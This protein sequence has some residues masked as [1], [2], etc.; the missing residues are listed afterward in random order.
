LEGLETLPLR[1]AKPGSTKCSRFSLPCFRRYCLVKSCYL[2]FIVS[3]HFLNSVWLDALEDPVAQR[4]Q[5]ALNASFLCIFGLFELGANP[6]LASPSP[7]SLPHLA[8]SLS[9]LFF[10]FCFSSGRH[11]RVKQNGAKEVDEH[12]FAERYR[13]ASGRITRPFWSCYMTPGIN[14]SAIILL[15]HFLGILPTLSSWSFHL[16]YWR[17]LH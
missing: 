5:I 8:D 15:C 13:L 12:V 7:R 11:A 14:A 17:F 10:L 1:S 2:A 16:E 4:C 9:E 3:L 6:L